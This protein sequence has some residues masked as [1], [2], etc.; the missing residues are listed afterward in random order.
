MLRTANSLFA[1]KGFGI[2]RLS[3]LDIR[4][5]HREGRRDFIAMF[6]AWERAAALPRQLLFG[7]SAIPL[8]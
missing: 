5:L 6:H 8:T 1:R 3:S 7:L 4:H 2:G